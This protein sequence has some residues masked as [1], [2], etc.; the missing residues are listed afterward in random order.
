MTRIYLILQ[1]RRHSRYTLKRKSVGTMHKKRLEAV[2]P[3]L[4]HY[5]TENLFASQ[6]IHQH[7]YAVFTPE[8]RTS[9]FNYSGA[10]SENRSYSGC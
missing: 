8:P 1:F 9:S 7:V 10:C 2:S 6:Q 3:V 4:R 5:K